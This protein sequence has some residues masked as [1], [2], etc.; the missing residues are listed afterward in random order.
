MGNA[1]K[2]LVLFTEISMIFSTQC[3]A[4]F[5]FSALD[6]YYLVYLTSDLSRSKLGRHFYHHLKELVPNT[7][8]ELL[9]CLLSHL[10]RILD[11]SGGRRLIELR[12]IGHG[13]KAT[14]KHL[15]VNNPGLSGDGGLAVTVKGTQEGTLAVNARLG[16]GVVGGVDVG[17]TGGGARAKS[18]ATSRRFVSYAAIEANQYKL[19]SLCSNRSPHLLSSSSLH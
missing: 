13:N 17:E 3:A 16:L 14:E 5:T 11:L 12:P 15:T 7:G 19:L 18:E 8:L 6:S 9:S 10:N 1:A 4:L 2:N